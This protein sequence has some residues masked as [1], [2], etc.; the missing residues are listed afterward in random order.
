MLRTGLRWDIA[1]PRAG[2]WHW[3]D[4][5]RLFALEARRG[6]ELLP[7]LNLTPPWAGSA[8]NE[9]PSRPGAFARFAA[10]VASRYGPGGQFWREHPKLDGKLAAGWLDV[11][12]EPYLN[13][14]SANDVNPGRYARLVRAVSVA[15]HNANPS[16]R[17][18]MEVNTYYETGT[19]GL[20]EDWI[21]ALYQAVPSLNRY[22]DAVSV[23]PYCVNP[24]T[25]VSQSDQS[26]QRVQV[27]H[28]ELAAHGAASKPLW[29]TEF[30]W[31]TCNEGGTYIGCVS[32]QTQAADLGEV[33]SYFASQPYIGA[34]FPYSY[35]NLRVQQYGLVDTYGLLD[36]G[37]QPK[38][39]YAVWL[40]FTRRILG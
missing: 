5:D 14:Y 33:L 13:A 31:S 2:T 19:G 20:I 29:A 37:G 11:W 23:H 28:D 9:I 25:P 34:L 17:L 18:L 8:W 12:N 22:F 36:W 21:D 1:Q 30:G 35:A 16:E 3:G 26:C 32:Y 38:P 39:A 24:L 15:V 27:I 7:V 4:Y 6:L 10:A 40:A